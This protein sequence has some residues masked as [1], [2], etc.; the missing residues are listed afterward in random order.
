MDFLLNVCC[1]K[2]LKLFSFVH[3]V[4]SVVSLVVL[5]PLVTKISSIFPF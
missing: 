2:F 5:L 4:S 1:F 3:H